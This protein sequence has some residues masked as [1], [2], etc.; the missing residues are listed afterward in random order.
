MYGYLTFGYKHWR[1]LIWVIGIPIAVVF[2]GCIC[3]CCFGCFSCCILPF[4]GKKDSCAIIKYTV[5]LLIV[6]IGLATIAISLF[7]GIH[8]KLSVD[9]AN[10]V[11]CA[12]ARTMNDIQYGVIDPTHNITFP[13]LQGIVYFLKNTK[14][15]IDLI[16]DAKELRNIKDSGL[17]KNAAN[18]NNE[19]TSFY[20]KYKD[21]EIL[22]PKSGTSTKPFPI[23]TLTPRINDIVDIEI[24]GLTLLAENVVKVSTMIYNMVNVPTYKAMIENTISPLQNTLEHVNS[25]ITYFKTKYAEN[26][27]IEDVRE[28]LDMTLIVF[29][30]MVFTLISVYILLMCFTSVLNCCTGLKCCSKALM[31]VTLT[32]GMCISGCSIKMILLSS[33]VLNGCF[34]YD[35]AVNEADFIPNITNNTITNKIFNTCIYQNASGDI[36]TFLPNMTN[37]DKLTENLDLFSKIDS[38][39]SLFKLTQ[40]Q[41]ESKSLSLYTNKV[42]PEFYS[43][44]VPDILANK[45]SFEE[46]LM[47]INLKANQLG[48]KDTFALTQ[49]KCPAGATISSENSGPKDGL[50][51]PYCILIPSYRFLKID[52]RYAGITDA[53]NDP[54]SRMKASVDAHSKLVGNMKTDSQAGPLIASIIYF[55]KVDALRSD[56]EAIKIKLNNSIAFATSLKG[57]FK[58]SINCRI[59][60]RELDVTSEALC[61]N[62]GLAKHFTQQAFIL[63]ILGPILAILGVCM[64][65]QTM[66]A[67]RDSQEDD[68]DESDR[69]RSLLL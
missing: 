44:E 49:N 64:F 60:R 32:C 55:Q 6:V 39:D 26:V 56:I 3:Q 40:S 41:K 42:L 47:S 69:S 7:W 50:G 20:K 5:I 46:S 28:G 4:F 19:I 13:G 21:S 33:L 36:L 24:K 16:T 17:D 25:N 8:V 30:G 62:D 37:F 43:F 22:S 52:E 31:H 57:I 9:S 61:S 2:L 18:I 11:V 51:N 53:L 58:E 23:Y 1:V 59:L 35:K 12:L 65:L 29:G 67:E 14:K 10:K 54:Y 45:E 27:Q 68:D 66:F 48:I 63:T 15:E 34:Y 38:F